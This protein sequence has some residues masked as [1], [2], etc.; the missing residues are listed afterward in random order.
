[1][2]GGADGMIRFYRAD[3]QPDYG[4]VKYRLFPPA[5][6]AQPKADDEE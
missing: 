6:Q 4:P 1:M 3:P 2:T 5:R